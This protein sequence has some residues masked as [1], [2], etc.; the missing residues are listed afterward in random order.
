M[1][2]AM[3]GPPRICHG[4]HAT[5]RIP[6]TRRC[7]RQHWACSFASIPHSYPL[8]TATMSGSTPLRAGSSASSYPTATTRRSIARRSCQLCRHRKTRCE[9]PDPTVPDGP[10]PLPDTRKCHRCKVLGEE[11]VVLAAGTRAG[12]GKKRKAED[13]ELRRETQSPTSIQDGGGERVE[14]LTTFDPEGHGP[15]GSGGGQNR[16]GE[17]SMQYHTRPITL[18]SAM[19]RRAFP[20]DGDDGEPDDEV[21]IEG[22]QE[23]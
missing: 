14:L 15:S 2:C 4:S 11:C 21:S 16:R 3:K 18:T 8:E 12:P 22:L 1:G 9:L 20:A 6:R 13:S 7:C 17:S 10:S 19:L 5:R 23:T